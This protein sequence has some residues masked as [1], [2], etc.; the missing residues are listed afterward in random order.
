MSYL[1]FG[2]PTFQLGE[3]SQSYAAL[4]VA[5]LSPSLQSVAAAQLRNWVG[6]AADFITLR[7]GLTDATR[8]QSDVGG[9]EAVREGVYDLF[10]NSRFGYEQQLSSN[11]FVSITTGFC[12]FRDAGTTDEK[13]LEGLSG[14]LEYRFSRDASIRAGKEP[15]N[16]IC[17][18]GLSAG[19][20]VEQ[21]SQ[22][23]LSLFKSW[24]F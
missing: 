21:P 1:I 3:R 9:N 10:W 13:F 20:I 18:A 19:R 8:L 4:A 24:R 16:A 17:R 14:K 2:Q 5:T 22:W 7:P 15:S 6:S 11:L 23:G 12:Q